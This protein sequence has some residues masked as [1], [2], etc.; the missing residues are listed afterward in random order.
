[1]DEVEFDCCSRFPREMCHQLAGA[2]AVFG[3]SFSTA[4]VL[5]FYSRRRVPS[6]DRTAGTGHARP[7]RRGGTPS[8]PLD[9]ADGCQFSWQV[10]G[11]SRPAPRTR[12]PDLS[13]GLQ[14]LGSTAVIQVLTVP[15]HALGMSVPFAEGDPKIRIVPQ[16]F[17]RQ[18]Q[19]VRK[20]SN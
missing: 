3:V 14:L 13:S 1:M 9:A 12:Y 16:V 17:V 6:N 7:A 18:A 4:A 2:N 10:P 15:E 8:R 5:P 20:G 11:P 19:L